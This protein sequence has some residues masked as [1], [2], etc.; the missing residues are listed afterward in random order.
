MTSWETIL[1]APAF[2]PTVQQA[3][4][5]NGESNEEEGEEDDLE[6]E[7]TTR[8][9]PDPDHDHGEDV[10]GHVRLPRG[11]QLLRGDGGHRVVLDCNNHRPWR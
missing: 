6:E 1:E 2:G 7:D 4:G 8:G 10:R 9:R 5:S 11:A 3:A